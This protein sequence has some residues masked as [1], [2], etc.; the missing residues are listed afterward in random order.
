MSDPVTEDFI[1]AL[2]KAELHMHLEGSLEPEHMFALAQRNGVDIGFRTA[3]EVRAAYSFTQ[4][5]DFLDLYYAGCSVLR[6]ER[7]FHEL[8]MAY[9][10]RVHAD[11]VRHVEL[12][13]DPQAHTGRGVAFEAVTDGILAALEEGR[14]R[15]GITSG[16]ILC[17]LRHLD[18]DDAFAT[19]R[20]AEPY[21]DRLLGVGLDSSE[22]GHPPAKFQRVFDAAGRAG[23][24]RV[25]HA[26]EEGPPGYVREALD[27]LHVDRIDH[28]NRAL[29]DA[30]LTA[31][32]AESGMTL[33]VCPLSNLSLCVID[34]M[35]SHPMRRMLDAGLHATVNSD[36]P[37]YFG[38]YMVDNFMALAR[39]IGLTREEAITLARNSITGAFL[40]DAGRAA[41]LQD[42][43]A[44]AGVA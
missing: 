8:T 9:L 18:E 31:R 22:Q 6:R 3:E 1:R 24:R 33:T 34:R 4:L 16:L 10:Q 29:E 11:G 36:D 38:G 14:A 13:Y 28:G 15:F 43:E 27:L 30:R 32:L 21:F 35:E 37:A 41:L 23:L 20:Q 25:A 44:C 2:P 17:L 12:F 42:L 26:G 5:Q 19:F 7:D 39:G 40:D